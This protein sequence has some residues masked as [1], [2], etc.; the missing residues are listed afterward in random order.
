MFVGGLR[1][2]LRNGGHQAGQCVTGSIGCGKSDS[3]TGGRHPVA[4]HN[5][6]GIEHI[7]RV[8]AGGFHHPCHREAEAVRRMQKDKV[9][10]VQNLRRKSENIVNT[11]SAQ[12]SPP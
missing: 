7:G 5:A 9:L 11:V 3:H 8:D 1:G 2:E 12:V 4:G 10:A 6:G